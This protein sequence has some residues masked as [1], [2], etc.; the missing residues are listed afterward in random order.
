MT[1]ASISNGSVRA[2][3]GVAGP[4]V[5]SGAHP[6]AGHAAAEADGKAR[7]LNRNPKVG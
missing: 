6:V 1:V 3:S 2:A 4:Q 7:Q 5:Q